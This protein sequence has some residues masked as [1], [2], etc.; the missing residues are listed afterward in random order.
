[1]PHAAHRS[2]RHVLTTWYNG[3]LALILC[4][5]SAVLHTTVANS[6]FAAVDDALA[7]HAAGIADTIDAFWKAER[8]AAASGPGNWAAAPSQSLADESRAGRLRDLIARWEQKTGQLATDRPV[9]LL[10]PDGQ[11]ITRSAGFTLFHLP[12]AEGT[13]RK[14]LRGRSVYETLKQTGVRLRVLTQPMTDSGETLYL[15]RSAASLDL[16]DASLRR[17]RLWLLLLI[18]ST[19][20]MTNSVGWFLATT[21]MRPVNQMIAQAQRIGASRVH[22]RIDVPRTG[23]ELERLAMT[24]NEMLARFEQ[25]FTRMRQFS[26]A[27]S[28]ELRTPLTVMKGE[29]EVALRRPRDPAEY[30]RVLRIHLETI[31]AMTRL[32]EELLGLAR[33]ETVEGTVE[34]RAIELGALAH[35]ARKAVHPLLKR[36]QVHLDILVQRP[37]WVHGEQRLLERAVA[38]LLDYATRQTPTGAAVRVRVEARATEARLTIE[39][40]G[41]GVPPDELPHVFDRFFSS[42]C[43]TDGNRST[44]LG[45]GLCRWIVEAH[46]GRITASSAPGQGTRI[47]VSLPLLPPPLTPG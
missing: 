3:I 31:D 47:G 33:S 14:A 13:R 24:F 16:V 36:K 42:S 30:Q 35:E 19:L 25:A 43:D 21:A 1:M 23:D 20:I 34:W 7:V 39:D 11:L 17:L 2:I 26:A 4:A 29:L 32:V 22:E 15:I 28:H 44:G 41:P 9:A 40:T 38:A 37:A 8:T 45:L 6:L 18:P 46:H 10:A 27:A 5:F 12:L